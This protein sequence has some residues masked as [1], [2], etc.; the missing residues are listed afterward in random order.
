MDAVISN[1]DSQ[2]KL[3]DKKCEEIAQSIKESFARTYKT[4][5]DAHKLDKDME[6]LD[7][8]IEQ[9]K[10][11]VSRDN[12]Q[13]GL[14]GLDLKLMLKDGGYELRKAS[15]DYDRKLLPISKTTAAFAPVLQC[16]GSAIGDAA[17]I[18]GVV[19]K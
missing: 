4:Y 11:S 16:A 12:I 13:L 5:K 1:L 7:N 19:L 6:Y 10:V 3:N 18:A 2:N 9:V 8:L 14:D 15:I 17:K